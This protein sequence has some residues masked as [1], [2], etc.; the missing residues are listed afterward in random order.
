MST[1]A[2]AL[3]NDEE[4]DYLNLSD[5]AF[6]K[7][8]EDIFDAPEAAEQDENVADVTSDDEEDDDGQEEKQALLV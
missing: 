7:L 2:S 6:E 3:E 4:V 5:D 8:G 1:E